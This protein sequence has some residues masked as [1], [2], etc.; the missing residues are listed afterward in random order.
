[1][2]EPIRIVL[3]GVAFFCLLLSAAFSER[4]RLCAFFLSIFL[5]TAICI[6]MLVDAQ[7]NCDD[8]LVKFVPAMSVL[9]VAFFWTSLGNVG[10]LGAQAEWVGWWLWTL[11]PLL[12]KFTVTDT[13]S[14]CL[15]RTT[16]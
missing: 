4:K 8:E 15:V 5:G 12:A 14:G 11:I 16:K 7:R 13:D 10:I 1:M 3:A 6:W 9:V 2:G